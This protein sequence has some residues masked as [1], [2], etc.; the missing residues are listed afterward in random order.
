[1]I[2]TSNIIFLPTL[3]FSGR[4]SVTAILAR[5]GKGD[6]NDKNMK[7]NIK[8]KM[9]IV[10]HC[11]RHHRLQRRGILLSSIASFFLYECSREVVMVLFPKYIIIIFHC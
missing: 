4:R 8:D 2:V 10:A 5:G 1:M 11:Q 9:K 7:D 6:I 3:S